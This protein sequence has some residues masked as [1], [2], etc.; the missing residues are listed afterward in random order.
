MFNFNGLRDDVAK[1]FG[2]FL[3]R[4]TS[5][6]KGNIHSVHITGS[7]IT[8][9]YIPK[10]SDI[11]SIFVLNNMDLDF[12]RLLAPL[13]KDFKK[14]GIAAPLIMTP[15]YIQNS[16]DVFPVEFLN[17]KLIHKTV[18]GEDILSS[19][20]VEKGNLR[21]QVERE[22]KSKLIWLRQGYLSTMGEKNALI[23]NISASISG[24][25]PVFRAIIF[26][27]GGTPPIEKYSVVKKLKEFAELDSDIFEKML[28]IKQNKLKPDKNEL[29]DL[30]KQYYKTTERLGRLI[31]ALEV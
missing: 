21:L 26:L 7:A 8:A 16:L 1:A 5:E 15:Q 22:L 19:L 13:G 2:R 11:N 17:F 20:T 9:D 23:E 14:D 30:F 10:K 31:D 4:I 27:T 6:Y 24:V 18:L 29:D 28:L 25:I 12:L 3:D